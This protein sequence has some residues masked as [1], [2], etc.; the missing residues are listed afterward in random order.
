MSRRTWLI[1]WIVLP[2]AYRAKWTS[3]GAYTGLA[4]HTH[5][6]IDQPP[7]SAWDLLPLL[8]IPLAVMIVGYFLNGARN[9]QQESALDTYL[10]TM[11]ALLL[12]KELKESTERS[13][14]RAVAHAQTLTVLRWLNG[15][16]KGAVVR[17]LHESSLL[18][19]DTAIVDLDGAD[20]EGTFL[21]GANLRGAFLQG[22]N[23]DASY[24]QQADLSMAIMRK[25]NLSETDLRE[26]N[27]SGAIL[28]EA[29]LKWAALNEANLRG[30]ILFDADL[31][32]AYLDRADLSGSSLEGAKLEDANL[33]GTFLEG[34]NLRG[35]SLQGADL[36]GAS[37][38]G[39]ELN[40]ASLQG[41]ELNGADLRGADLRGAGGTMLEQLEQAASLQGTIM[42]DGSTHS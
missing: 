9:R 24:L 14:V 10:A 5:I 30:A 27:L 41:A 34:A 26:A 40:G 16:R 32:G 42:P 22:A 15:E 39:A 35:T 38:Q 8:V 18:G 31:E 3:L 33:R 1:L 17:F 2:W 36:R 28:V 19:M 21:E 37:L 20:L 12:D 11:T 4:I 29:N 13:E 7:K 25:V 23:L 6:T